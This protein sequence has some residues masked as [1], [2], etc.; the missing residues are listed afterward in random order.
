MNKKNA[1][2]ALLASVSL[3]TGF[4]AAAQCVYTGP[5]PENPIASEYD[6]DSYAFSRERGGALKKKLEATDAGRETLNIMQALG[7]RL[8]LTTPTKLGDDNPNDDLTI[9][10]RTLGTIIALNGTYS[11]KDLLTTLTHEARHIW[12]NRVLSL[13]ENKLNPEAGMIVN[14]YKEADAF[15][16]EFYF[17]Y[18]HEKATGE[19]LISGEETPYERT[20]ALFKLDM[21]SGMPLSLAYKY[22]MRRSFELV[23]DIGYDESYLEKLNDDWSCSP[24]KAARMARLNT[25]MMPTNASYPDILKDLGAP[26]YNIG[27]REG[28]FAQKTAQELTSWEKI[29]G[30]VPEDLKKL[31]TF[32]EKY[33]QA[34]KGE[35]RPPSP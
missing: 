11:D 18:R 5:L 32:E 15:A 3:M 7:V 34:L 12:Q 23:R 29:G 35:N 8:A 19:K 14:R 25:T 22:L 20:Y 9:V 17:A 26:D 1:I 16:Y 10:G 24:D 13:N 30:I 6:E 28:V 4:N 27:T 31:K 2:A 21:D 33:K